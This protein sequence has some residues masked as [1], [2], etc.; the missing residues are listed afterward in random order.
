MCLF[1]LLK[2]KIREFHAETEAGITVMICFLNPCSFS[3]FSLLLFN[4]ISQSFVPQLA[5]IKFS[6]FSINIYLSSSLSCFARLLLF[7]AFGWK[8]W[9][10]TD[11]FIIFI[12]DG[13]TGD[14]HLVRS[15]SEIFLITWLWHFFLFLPKFSVFFFF[16]LFFTW[17]LIDVC[18]CLP[19]S[20]EC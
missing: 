16:C 17:C 6:L 10:I 20:G 15:S 5:F 7:L 19:P 8:F 3:L 13:V 12:T 4:L 14:F 11:L 1:V 9:H 2:Q 18:F